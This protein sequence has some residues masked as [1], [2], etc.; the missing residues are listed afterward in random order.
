[1]ILSQCVLLIRSVILV[2]DINL[3]FVKNFS[4]RF[5][6]EL[7]EIVFLVLSFVFQAMQL[8]FICY[9]G[10]SSKQCL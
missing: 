4:V 6:Q 5:V 9:F 3:C 8:F 7:C 1:M 2:F 10:A